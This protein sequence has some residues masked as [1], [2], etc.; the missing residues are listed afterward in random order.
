[1]G[2][3]QS[4]LLTAPFKPKSSSVVSSLGSRAPDSWPVDIQ[5]KMLRCVDH[6]HM[7]VHIG[8]ETVFN[9]LK[10]IR[11]SVIF[12]ISR[13]KGTSWQWQIPQFYMD[14]LHFL[15]DFSL[16]HLIQARCSL[17]NSGLPW[18]LRPHAD[19]PISQSANAQWK[20]CLWTSL[21]VQ[22]NGLV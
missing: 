9:P 18:Y 7:A 8:R 2:R 17:K 12:R 5:Q 4:Y 1:M 6:G 10:T 20:R 13:T 19:Q 16:P 11:Y 14:Y 22:L 3:G 21:M 15:R